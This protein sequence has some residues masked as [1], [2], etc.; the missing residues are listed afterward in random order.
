[1]LLEPAQ[2]RP[3]QLRALRPVPWVLSALGLRDFG[4]QVMASAEPESLLPAVASAP[5]L[6]PQ[7]P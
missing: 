5:E 2:R 7:V 4:I 6:L 3:A 1:M